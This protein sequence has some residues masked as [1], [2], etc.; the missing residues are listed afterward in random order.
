[1]QGDS[2][3]DFYQR[4]VA[5]L[6]EGAVVLDLGAGR[7]VMFAYEERSPLR[8][9]LLLL[10][11]KCSRRI[12][13]D[14]IPEVKSNPAL[15][16][17]IVIEAGK[18]L[19]F[20]DQSFDLILC[21]WVL[22]HIADLEPFAAEVRR[23]LKI[24]GWFCARTPNRWSY[25]AMGSQILP[26]AL[27]KIAL[28]RFD[29]DGEDRDSFQTYYRLNMLGALAG[30]FPSD[31]WIDANYIHQEHSKYHGNRPWLYRLISLYQKLSD[32]VA[33]LD[34]LGLHAQSCLTLSRGSTQPW[35]NFRSLSIRA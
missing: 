35:C 16:E 1:M 6:P 12:G 4:V 9:W 29:P 31:C 18:P 21:D 33:R 3:V 27:R 32:P 15:D 19:P 13:V 11:K 14:V 26:A 17:A 8:R 34:Y 28:H 25:F 22:E 23:I 2:T 24:G 5:V 10:G 7:G 20:A 30:H